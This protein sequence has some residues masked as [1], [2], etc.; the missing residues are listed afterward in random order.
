MKKGWRR[1][2]RGR[3][4]SQQKWVNDELKEERE[5]EKWRVVQESMK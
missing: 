4:E 2:K 3:K 5:N 1:K